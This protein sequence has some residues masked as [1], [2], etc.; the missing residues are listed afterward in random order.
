MPSIEESKRQVKAGLRSHADSDHNEILASLQDEIDRHNGQGFT[1]EK[2]H[3]HSYRR[4]SAQD[5]RSTTSMEFRFKAGTS[6]P[7]KRRHRSKDRADRRRRK[8]KKERREVALEE[9]G[10][11]PF[12]REPTDP[13]QPRE[14]DANAAFRQ[15][16]FDA[17]ADDEGAAYWENVYSQPIHVYA[18][19]TVQT[20]KGELEE[21]NDEQYA[22]Y[23]QRRMWEKKHPEIVLERERKEKQKREEGEERTRRREEFIR[24][25]ERAA[26]ERAQKHGARKFAGLNGDDEADGQSY[27]YAFDHNGRSNGVS[28]R[29]SLDSTQQEF[30]QAWPKYLAAWDRLKIDLLNERDGSSTGTERK[31][32]SKRIPWPVLNAK[33][34][35][36]SNIENFMQQIPHDHDGRT[37]IQLLKSERVKWHPDKVQQRFAGKVDEGTMKLVTG[38]FQVV[39]AILES[40]RK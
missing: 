32:P 15:S 38:V 16:L 24:R 36:K 6:D 21:M 35:T 9:E 1:E 18:R 30:R 23:V 8:H 13:D 5:D 10:I 33:P 12:P 29:S 37:K 39:D 17:L 11:H 28:K 34:V 27:E 2:E 20:P 14:E 7:R 3:S 26:W 19:P 22:A 25:K 40:E 4:K 31:D